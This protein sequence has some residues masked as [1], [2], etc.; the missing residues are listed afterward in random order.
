M[1]TH[2]LRGGDPQSSSVASTIVIKVF[3][4]LLF[5]SPLLYAFDNDDLREEK[6]LAVAAAATL[7]LCIY[8]VWRRLFISNI[9]EIIVIFLFASLVIVQQFFIDNGTAAFG[10]KYAVVLLATFIPYWVA[11]TLRLGPEI[12][13]TATF[14]IG[15][16]FLVTVITISVSYVF[17]LGEVYVEGNAVRAFGWLG[18]SFT[19]VIV[20]LAIYYYFQS[21]YL[22][23]AVA[24]GMLLM[25]GGKAAMFMLIATPGVLIFSK[26]STKVKATVAVG[27]LI[28][29]LVLFR[30]AA[31]IV[32]KLIESPA[33]QYSF[34]TR[35]LSV[36]NGLN[37]FVG[38]PA[39]GV[40]IN[41][42][43]KFVDVDS[44][45]LAN[46]LKV[47]S[48]YEV[49]QIH[50]AVIRTAAE[51]GVVGL[52][53]LLM[54]FYL[55]LSSAYRRLRGAEYLTDPS[56]R[57]IVQA[58]S[59]WVISFVLFYQT[60]GWFEAGHP[61]LSW[62]LLFST[63]SSVFFRSCVAQRRLGRDVLPYAHVNVEARPR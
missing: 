43:M 29:L 21:K 46:D 14:A 38:A 8:A 48:Y 3:F 16:L 60:T 2:A 30:A 1:G 24:F 31:P 39:T 52:A 37:Y 28:S 42:S 63:L 35:L 27:C 49:Y 61:Q 11:D 41:Q 36:Y 32:E 7:F 40:G 62:L 44:A 53:L 56:G 17:G 50:N 18:D 26:A 33:L 55:L 57:A 20:F 47:D 54:F 12:K 6:I 58:S 59:L 51:T 25:T 23:A 22:F 45:S 10:I 13:K 4:L 34:N 15:L 19:P 5:F 9:K